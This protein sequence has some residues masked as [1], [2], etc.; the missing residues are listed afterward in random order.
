MNSNYLATV[1]FFL[2]VFVVRIFIGASGIDN[3]DS[4]TQLNLSWLPYFSEFII[5]LLFLGYKTKNKN[6]GKLKYLEYSLIILISVEVVQFTFV[7]FSANIDN[8]LMLI[9]YYCRCLLLISIN[10]I[11]IL[12]FFQR[13]IF[14]SVFYRF[15]SL[16]IIISLFFLILHSVFNLNFQVHLSD[17]MTR[18]QGLLSEPSAMAGMLSAFIGV[19][20]LKKNWIWFSLALVCSFFTYSVMVYFTIVVTLFFLLKNQVSLKRIILY[21]SIGAVSVF[22]FFI[23]YFSNIEF[24]GVFLRLYNI[25]GNLGELQKLDSDVLKNLDMDRIYGLFVSVENLIADKLL[26]TGY[27]L[28]GSSYVFVQRYDEVMDY[29]LIA[30]MISN[31]GIIV[32]L[33]FLFLGFKELLNLFKKDKYI[34]IIGVCFFIAVLGNSAGG[35][36]MYGVSFSLIFYNLIDNK[37]NSKNI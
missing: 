3:Y 28:N 7:F 14:L 16:S 11:Y 29:G 12:F 13:D 5:L 10:I 1:F 36:I 22:G 37:Y 34:G 8:I 35:I 31:F 4:L 23:D 27:G 9:I 20:L 15:A 32:G 24:D 26:F 21:V 17:G 33:I 6:N 18:V 19:S 25:I 2:Q 30:F